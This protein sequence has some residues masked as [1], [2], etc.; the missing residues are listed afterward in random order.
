MKLKKIEIEN[1]EFKILVTQ[2]KINFNKNSINLLDI[3]I[4]EFIKFYIDE[5]D[6]SY[7]YLMK[8]Y[9]G[10]PIKFSKKECYCNYPTMVKEFKL[11][12]SYS[13]EKIDK[14]L[15]RFKIK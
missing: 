7:I 11:K 4:G 9:K 5:E 3:N 15:F 10:I 8:T 2:T 14:N 12:G 1:N 13:I 6:N